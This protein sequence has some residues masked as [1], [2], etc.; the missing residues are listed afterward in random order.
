[1][2]L[3]DW[4]DREGIP[5]AAFAAEIGVS[6]QSLHRYKKKQRIPRPP[7]MSRIHQATGGEVAANDFMETAHKKSLKVVLRTESTNP[8]GDLQQVAG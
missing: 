7:T 8:R 3:S 1:M 5:D 4:L 6:R 2:Q